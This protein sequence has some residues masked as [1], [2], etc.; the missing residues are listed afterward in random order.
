MDINYT[1]ERTPFHISKVG[2]AESVHSTQLQ[3]SWV[4]RIQQFPEP[5]KEKN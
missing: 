4:L 1:Y 3:S 5:T 2:G